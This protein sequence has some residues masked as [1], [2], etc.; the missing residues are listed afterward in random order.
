MKDTAAVP[1]GER[2]ETQNLIHRG[3]CVGGKYGLWI[4]ELGADS[5]EDVQSLLQEHD[6]TPITDTAGRASDEKYNRP[7]DHDAYLCLSA[8]DA[9]K[10]LNTDA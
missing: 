7:T 6:V 3:G 4:D 9:R 5:V 1:R 2:P 8:T 10:I